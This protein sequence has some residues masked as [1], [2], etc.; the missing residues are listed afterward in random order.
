VYSIRDYVFDDFAIFVR[1]RLKGSHYRK[2][3]PWLRRMNGPTA[4]AI[5]SPWLDYLIAVAQK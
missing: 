5:W 3:H 2:V 1:H 4:V